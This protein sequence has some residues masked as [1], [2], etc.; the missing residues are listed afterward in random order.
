MLRAKGAPLR[1]R[2]SASA[3]LSAALSPGLWCFPARLVHEAWD[4]YTVESPISE[5]AS[6]IEAAVAALTAAGP[7]RHS[8]ILEVKSVDRN[9]VVVW[10]FTARGW[11]DVVRLRLSETASGGT[12]VR[13]HS[14]STGFCPLEQKCAVPLNVLCCCAPFLGINATRLA[15]LKAAIVE[16]VARGGAQ[17][18]GGPAAQAM[19]DRS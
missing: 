12:H 17:A 8:S 2:E 1:P 10:A 19:E 9:S 6:L 14:W 16:Q 5:V 11:L 3:A 18:A 4:S 13:G 7:P 15:M